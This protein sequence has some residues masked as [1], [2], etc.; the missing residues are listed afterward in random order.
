METTHTHTILHNM[1]VTLCA[2]NSKAGAGN[3]KVK[4][5]TGF[6]KWSCAAIRQEL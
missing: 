3:D 5:L 1:L 2:C 4:H 6:D